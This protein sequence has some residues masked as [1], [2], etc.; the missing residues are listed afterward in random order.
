MEPLAVGLL[1]LSAISYVVACVYIT[2]R[3]RAALPIKEG[4]VPAWTGGSGAGIVVISLLG[5]GVPQGVLVAVALIAAG[6]AI[7]RL[8]GSAL[9]R[10][11]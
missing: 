5:F 3:R 4:I 2:Y 8:L 7:G 10:A 1:T 9:H 11:T 6:V